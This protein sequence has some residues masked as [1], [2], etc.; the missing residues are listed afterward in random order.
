MNAFFKFQTGKWTAPLTV[1]I[2]AALALIAFGPL[3]VE[4][5]NSFPSSGLPESAESVQ[6]EEIRQQLPQSGGSLAL[7]VYSSD[8]ELTSEQL[9][10]IQG[11]PNPQTKTMVGGANEKFLAFSNLEIQGQ[12]V[13]PP[14]EISEDGKAALISIPLDAAEEF[15]ETTERI[16]SMRELAPQ[17][18]PEGLEVHVTGP[19]AFNKDLGSI[20]EGAND[21]LITTT[22]IV[23][24]LLLL[25][26]YRSPVLWIIP[27]VIVGVADGAG[28]NLARQVAAAFG[29]TPDASVV[30]I[31][32]VLVFGAGTNY[33]LLLISRY[34]EELLL[35]EDRREA[36]R[37]AVRGAGPA[38]L[39]SG[40]TVAVAVGLLMLAELEGRQVLGLVSAVGIVVAMFAGLVILP[41]ALVMFPRQIF[42]PL[43]PKFGAANPFEKSIWSKLGTQVS[44]RP[45]AISAIGIILLGTL[46]SGGLGIKTGLSATEVFMEKPEAVV[47]QEVLAESFSAG[48]ANPTQVIVST[49]IV[50]SATDVIAGV[51]GV[52]EITNAGGTAEYTQL[53]VVIDAE[54]ESNAAYDIIREL[55]AA[56]DGL[57][58]EATALVGG[59][60]ATSMDSSDATARDQALLVPL[61][62]MAVFLILIL[63]LRSLLTPV[64]LLLAVVG[65]FFSAVGASWLVFQYILGFPAL[66]L[67]VFVIAFLFL[68][69]LGVD[70]SIFLV[71]RAQEEA[72]EFGT[73]E[74]MR[75]A[76]GAT[77]G[78]ITSAGILLAAV[79]SVLG[80]LPLVSLAQI[81][82]IVCIGV[83]LDT[84]LVRT[85]LVP[86]MAFKLGAKFWWPRKEFAD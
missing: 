61:I 67:S 69:A 26:T 74:G 71:T 36:M 3:A 59:Q 47:G 77:G 86:A 15:R 68:V 57:S 81:G 55:R 39:A 49:S 62:L 53:D 75:R 41:A 65:S 33:A 34:R 32:S 20:F 31:L 44:K 5:D 70:Y 48:A 60:D 23:V 17:G 2:G 22:A 83:L 84:L 18:M 64:L 38:I 52:D 76:L 78:V 27:L 8:E 10:W 21:T 54:P 72:V 56:L 28:G 29:Y 24:A 19:E 1:L 9:S 82:I 50:D 11:T 6:A 37:A 25:I 35:H 80:V 45:V 51:E 85:V 4:E 46:A 58:N 40:S 7:V 66:E 30:G 63:L 73:R 43:I 12:V 42:W 14:A 13:V 16:E 79:F